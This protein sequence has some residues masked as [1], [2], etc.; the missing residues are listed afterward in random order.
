MK[1]RLVSLVSAAVLSALFALPAC[2][3]AAV[4][5]KDTAGEMKEYVMDSVKREI[6]KKAEEGAADYQF[7]VGN[8]YYRGEEVKQD[9]TQAVEWFVR[10]ASGGNAEAQYALG[11]LYIRGEGVKRDYPRA[12]MWL[13]RS[14]GQGHIRAQY[15]LGTLY[16]KGEGVRQDLEMAR[17]WYAKAGDLGDPNANHALGEMC[18]KGEGGLQSKSA[19]AERYYKAGMKMLKMGY[20]DEAMANLD[21]LH[22]VFPQSPYLKKLNDAIYADTSKDKARE[23][24]R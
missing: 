9:L 2:K 15:L 18:E 14:G 16:Q 3:P 23:F 22:R 7:L 13:K 6:F 12:A 8:M 19:A 4:E 5:K 1:Y 24:P 10:S 21:A 20:R 17:E 11:R